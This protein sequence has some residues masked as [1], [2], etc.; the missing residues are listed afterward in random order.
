MNSLDLKVPPLLLTLLA[1]V[2][3]WLIASMDLLPVELQARTLVAGFFA[4]AG[5]CIAAAGVVAFRRA[6]TTVNPL[7]PDAASSLI[8]GG[9]YRF[10]RN[11]MYLGFLLMLLGWSV[12]LGDA[13]TLPVVALF[14]W[15]LNRFQIEPEE[16]A[17]AA[18]FGDGFAR[19][20]RRVRRWL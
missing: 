15:Y 20:R 1:A 19:Y 8:D 16:K 5:V 2:G 18:R 3:M 12:F 14:I 13:A 17:L 6:R 10:T 9:V 11:P 7:T 4:T